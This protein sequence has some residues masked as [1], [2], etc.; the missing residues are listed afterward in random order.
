MGHR[1][2]VHTH[3]MAVPGLVDLFQ[4]LLLQLALINSLNFSFPPPLGAPRVSS[5][6]LRLCFLPFPLRVA[7]AL[8]MLHVALGLV[9]WAPVH[10][11]AMGRHFG[12]GWLH[13]LGTVC[14]H[15]NT[16]VH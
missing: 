10:S 4:L 3:S 15:T 12:D 1:P 6:P 2:Q 9:S 7:P 5:V 11:R 13:T 8:C 14:T 16:A